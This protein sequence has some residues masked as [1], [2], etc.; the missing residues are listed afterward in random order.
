MISTLPSLNVD[1]KPVVRRLA[2][3]EEADRMRLEAKPS[4]EY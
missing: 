1:R 4:K 3:V 2:P